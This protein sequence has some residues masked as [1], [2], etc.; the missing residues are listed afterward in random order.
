V[1]T[2]VEL[3][4]HATFSSLA[5]LREAFAA[6]LARARR[7]VV[8]WD[9]PDVVSLLDADAGA[10]ANSGVGEVVRFDVPAPE[11]DA[12]GARFR[13]R[14]ESV[15]LVVP[16]A[17][18]ALNAAAALEAA[19]LAGA[20]ARAAVA[21]L[22][23]FRGA[24]RR[25]QLLGETAQGAR[26][27]DDYAH[28]PT[29]VA[30]TLAAARTLAPARLITVFQPHL[31]SRTRLLAREFGRALAVADVIVVLDVYA[32]RELAAEH[33]GVSG[34]AI[35]EAAVDAAAGRAVYWLPSFDDA[36]PVL[37]QLLEQGDVCVVMGAGDI[38]ALART[39]VVG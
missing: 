23:G 3:D 7:A 26:V 5:D 9:R 6:F 36:E 27:Y 25:F 20:E 15:R 14:D 1:L 4:H 33:P 35:A 37:A 12:D 22:A 38:D 8:V 17:H 11:L 31:Y 24:R 28:H 34:L 39:L 30:A 16:G 19:R 21:G 2:N 10:N 13:W 29:E 32:A 18:N